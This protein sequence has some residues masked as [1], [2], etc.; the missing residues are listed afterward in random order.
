MGITLKYP[1]SGATTLSVS[2]PWPAPQ[3]PIEIEPNQPE[4]RAPSGAIWTVQ[5]GPPIYR[6]TRTFESLTEA[7]VAA[8]FAFLEGV[9]FAI[10]EIAYCYHDRVTDTDVA[11]PCR[12]FEPPSE[13][14]SQTQSHDVSLVFEQFTHPDAVTETT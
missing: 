2:L 1:A 9:G 11:V 8:L 13:A 3:Q 6:I 4:Y 12:I 7:E 14:I 5:V 10:N